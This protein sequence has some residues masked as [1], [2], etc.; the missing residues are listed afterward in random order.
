[1]QNKLQKLSQKKNY[2]VCTAV[3][4]CLPNILDVRVLENINLFLKD[5]IGRP[6]LC[7]NEK[8]FGFLSSV[9]CIG[10]QQCIFQQHVN[11]IFAWTLKCSISVRKLHVL[12]FIFS[13]ELNSVC[14]NLLT[15]KG[16]SYIHFVIIIIF[17][18]FLIILQHL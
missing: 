16:D 4:R 10:C 3:A 8:R 1:L 12:L 11:F 5:E 2:M 15:S 18:V 6:P 14:V 13:Y 9:G 7:S 17:S